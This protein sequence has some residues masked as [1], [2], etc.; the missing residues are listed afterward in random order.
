LT[1]AEILRY[2][3]SISRGFADGPHVDP[4]YDRIVNNRAPS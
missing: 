2:I 1:A 3:S 4:R